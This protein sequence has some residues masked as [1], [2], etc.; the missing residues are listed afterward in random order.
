M[1]C[2]GEEKKEKK[3]KRDT[4]ETRGTGEKSMAWMR[5]LAE[6][7]LKNEKE[8]RHALDV[9]N[10]LE[11]FL[12]DVPDTENGPESGTWPEPGIETMPYT[13]DPDEEV[14]IDNVIEHIGDGNFVYRIDGEKGVKRIE[15]R[16]GKIIDERSADTLSMMIG[17]LDEGTAARE[18]PRYYE[19]VDHVRP[20]VSKATG[21]SANES[22][23]ILE[24]DSG[25]R[26]LYDVLSSYIG[27]GNVVKES[28]M[29]WEHSA[30][31]RSGAIWALIK[32]PFLI[33]G[34]VAD[35]IRFRRFFNLFSERILGQYD[36]QFD[37]P[38][39]ALQ[40]D[41]P[42]SEGTIRVVSSNIRKYSAKT[43]NDPERMENYTLIHELI[44]DTQGY[45]NPGF[46]LELK[47]SLRRQILSSSI[48]RMG[49]T[50]ELPKAKAK[51]IYDENAEKVRAMMT[52][53]E[54][55]ATF[56]TKKVVDEVMSD[57]AIRRPKKDAMTKLMDRLYGIDKLGKRYDNGNRFVRYLYDE[58]GVELTRLPFSVFPERTEELTSPETYMKRV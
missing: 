57:F 56:Y 6:S 17:P 27:K 11:D 8:R 9:I 33:P 39:P 31:R 16:I 19:Y 15:G 4:R 5:D 30:N 32:A 24:Y 54:G 50:Q 52:F 58:G 7:S 37:N 38:A 14:T 44:H 29:L 22:L 23:K 35:N 43:G 1:P 46:D 48:L 3:G 47:R 53:L 21:L 28:Y 55:H 40:G 34:M 51:A 13:F 2:S 25:K 26:C 45:S 41:N 12:N 18:N 10:A 36:I 20:V 42:L 49:G